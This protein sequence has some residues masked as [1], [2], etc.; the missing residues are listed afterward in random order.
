M[1]AH[2]S[3]SCVQPE[4]R[5]IQK[6]PFSVHH[7][8][9]CLAFIGRFT[10][11]AQTCGLVQGLLT[12]VTHRSVCALSLWNCV[13]KQ[14][15]RHHEDH[16][17]LF[18]AWRCYHDVKPGHA[19]VLLHIWECILLLENPQS[20]YNCRGTRTSLAILLHTPSAKQASQLWVLQGHFI[21]RAVASSRKKT[22][23]SVGSALSSQ[24]WQQKASSFDKQAELNQWNN[25]YGPGSHCV[26]SVPALRHST[27]PCLSQSWFTFDLFSL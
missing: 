22:A 16:S 14:H 12:D 1:Q 8:L 20:P 6:H 19:E 26:W 17:F 3:F 21:F 24:C 7:S 25:L 13:F 2:D 18:Q 9:W 4:T 23:W 27:A 10:A 11:S 15:R 5:L